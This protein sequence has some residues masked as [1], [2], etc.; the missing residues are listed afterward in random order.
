MFRTIAVLSVFILV[1]LSNC[2]VD[3]SALTKQPGLSR[4]VGMDLRSLGWLQRRDLRNTIERLTSIKIRTTPAKI[5][6]WW[7]AKYESG[8]TYWILF[9]GYEGL[10]IPDLSHARIHRFDEFWKYLGSFAFPTG[11][12][13]VLYEANVVKEPILGMDVIELRTTPNLRQV[14]VVAG[15]RAVLVRLED[16]KTHKMVRREYHHRRPFVGPPSQERS[17]EE[18]ILSLDSEDPVT[19]LET[20]IWLTGRHLPSD[21]ERR[22]NV[23]QESIKHSKIYEVVRDSPLVKQ[24]L[25]VLREIPNTWI[26]E[27]VELATESR[28]EKR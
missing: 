17:A 22:P 19:V 9:E 28:H 26:R 24:K 13:S 1:F 3:Q 8:E 16:G 23:Y 7:I 11:Y 15:D 21:E 10:N 12:R 4:Y 5:H 20:L 2:H 18:W 14:Y 25:L 27:A 6:P